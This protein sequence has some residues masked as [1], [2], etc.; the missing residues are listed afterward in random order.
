MPRQ[1][2]PL[3]TYTT[4][5]FPVVPRHISRPDWYT[6]A[7]VIR[8]QFDACSAYALESGVVLPLY[9]IVAR[10]IGYEETLGRQP[11]QYSTHNRADFYANALNN[12]GCWLD[13]VV[14]WR[15]TGAVGKACACGAETI[16]GPIPEHMLRARHI[17]CKACA[18]SWRLLK[19]RA[20]ELGVNATGWRY[21]SDNLTATQLLDGM[22]RRADIRARYVAA[23]VTRGVACWACMLGPSECQ[24]FGENDTGELRAGQRCSQCGVFR[25]PWYPEAPC[26]AGCEILD[27][28]GNARYVRTSNGVVP[29]G[30]AEPWAPYYIGIEVETDSVPTARLLDGWTANTAHCMGTGTDGSVGGCESRTQPIRGLDFIRAIEQVSGWAHLCTL[31]H[32]CGLHMHVDMSRATERTRKAHVLLWLHVERELFDL[33]GEHRRRSTYAQPLYNLGANDQRE[34]TDNLRSNAG[35][36]LSLN[37]TSYNAHRTHEARIWG[38]SDRVRERNSAAKVARYI[39]DR[40]R[41]T[42]ALRVAAR[43]LATSRGNMRNHQ[44][45]A[46]DART[47]LA[48][49]ISLVPHVPAGVSPLLDET[50][51]TL[52]RWER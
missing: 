6:V 42:W 30:S 15:S 22:F 21:L 37:V 29:V 38:W 47:A 32:R 17:H 52:T 34:L 1:P 13:S 24:C 14:V 20:R 31:N 11:H 9:R 4:S 44:I 16:F 41:V 27:G 18:P 36:Y 50:T 48:Y 2:R 28:S 39:Y 49:M 46:L 19:R 45:F 23:G 35:R 10:D 33:A 26:A 40:A 7:E 43:M 3:R 5:L 25:S 12:R 8:Y 51:S